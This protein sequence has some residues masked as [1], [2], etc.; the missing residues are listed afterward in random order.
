MTRA[1]TAFSRLRGPVVPLNICFNDDGTVDY[2]SVCN[3]VD[4]LCTQKA[5]VILLTYGSTEFTWLT[6]EDLWEL[7]AAVGRAIDGRSLYVTS[8]GFWPVRKARQFLKH[9]DAAGAD[10]VK[11]QISG[12]DP[13]SAAVIKAYFDDLGSAGTDIPM[14]MWWHP[15]RHFAM[16]PPDLA[17]TF[18]ELAKRP[19]IIGIKN[20]GDAFYDYYTLAR[21]MSDSN[22]AVVSGGL[23]RNF[24]TGYPHGSPA[25]LC[26]IAPFCP[27]IAN[28]FYNHVRNG[29]TDEAWDIVYNYEDPLMHAAQNVN[30]LVLMKSAVMMLGFYP[31]NRVGNPTQMCA[32]GEELE[33]IQSVY[34]DLF[35]LAAASSSS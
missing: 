31:N 10:A 7:T 21:G 28:Q 5:P 34:S 18:I 14:L 1:D 13:P 32:T 17:Q 11:V 3:Y 35:G 12:W 27:Q 26:P 15:V 22:C 25:Y 16:L 20:D 33:K 8:T 24:L 19:D 9:A 29:R 23:M 30:W 4:W 6:D 2:A